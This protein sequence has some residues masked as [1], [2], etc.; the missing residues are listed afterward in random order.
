MLIH[1]LLKSEPPLEVWAHGTLEG[2]ERKL[3]ERPVSSSRV[4]R[5]AIPE[6]CPN[7]TAAATTT[8]ARATIE[9]S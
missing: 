4:H 6:G 8:E 7:R 9:R 5:D 3:F 2:Q 1:A